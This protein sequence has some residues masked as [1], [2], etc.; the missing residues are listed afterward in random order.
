MNNLSL[1]TVLTKE[2]ERA[3]IKRTANNAFRSNYGALEVPCGKWLGKGKENIDFACYAPANQEITCCEIKI[4]ESDFNSPASLSFYGNRN[5]LV[6]PFGLAKSI[7]TTLQK[8]DHNVID[9]WT[10][11]KDLLYRGVGIMGYLPETAEEIKQRYSDQPGLRD[12]MLKVLPKVKDDFVVLK[13]CK[14]KAIHFA[15]K[16]SLI[17][18]I[19]RAGCRDASKYYSR[20]KVN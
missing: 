11:K 2:I 19:L 15:Q 4:T 13:Y 9:S 14:V 8:H 6:A 10:H 5:Y 16:M 12:T 7:A 18:G 3:L 1:K 20:E 17:E